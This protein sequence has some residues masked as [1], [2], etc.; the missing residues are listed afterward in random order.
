MRYDYQQITEILRQI[1]LGNEAAESHGVLCGLLCTNGEGAQA[2]W[3]T[4][5]MSQVGEKEGL[6]PAALQALL[7]PIVQECQQQ[8][9]STEC[10][11]QPVIPQD[12][13]SVSEKTVAL[14]HWAQGFLVG[15]SFGGVKDLKELPENA[16]EILLDFTKIAQA[17]KY[18]I[19][20]TEEDDVAFTEIFEYLRAGVLLVYQ[21]LNPLPIS[22]PVDRSRL[23]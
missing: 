1:G 9:T 13:T 22:H 23:H 6:S 2:R 4:H 14:A 21:E 16:M 3:S 19:D 5:I 18:D 10:D 7:S 15:M 8:L 12:P 11:F 20:G 17:G